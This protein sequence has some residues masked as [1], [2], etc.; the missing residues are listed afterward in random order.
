MTHLTQTATWCEIHAQ[1]DIWGEWAAPQYVAFAKVLAAVFSNGL[2]L[3]VD[4]PFAGKGALARVVSN[5]K[6]HPAVP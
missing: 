3:N 2:G 5:A 1:P 4:N 6:L